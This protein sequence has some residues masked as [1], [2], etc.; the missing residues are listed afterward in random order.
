MTADKKSRA[1]R[2]QQ[3]LCASLLLLGMLAS[4]GPASADAG[5]FESGDTQLRLDLLLL[6]DARVIRLPVS[7]WPL[8]RA[9][10]Q[11]ALANAKDHF[12]TNAA[13][14]TA[15]ARL[16]ARMV[17]AGD[18][19]RFAASARAGEAGLLR[20]FDSI[21]REDAEIGGRA[22]YTGR[23]FAAALN[24]TAAVD[25]DDGQQLRVDGSHVTVALGN[26]LVSANTLER[27]W[28]PSHE[29]SLIL[30]N[31]A[32]P[33]PTLMVE[34]A[35]AIP[36]ETAWLSWLGPWRFNFAISQMENERRD[37]DAPLFMAWR[38]T[39]MPFKDIEFGV[40]RTAQFCGKQL[41]CNLSVFGNLLV[42]NDNVGID[43]T[44]ENEPGNQMAGFDIRWTSPLG[45]WPYAVYSQMIGEDE[46]SYFPAK[47]LAQYGAEMWKPTARGGLVQV[48]AEYSS[49]TCSAN[50]NRGPYYNCAY[51]QGRFNTEGYRYRGRVI[52]YTSD[53][54]AENYAIGATFTAPDGVLWSA[55]ARTAVLNRD[56]DSDPRNTVS[57]VRADYTALELGWKGRLFG[58]AVSVDL[59]VESLEPMNGER[60]FG[61]FGFIGWR[62]EFH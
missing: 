59:G 7:Q 3:V 62:H 34:R 42:G 55:T 50:T 35:A 41:E 57:S 13:V 15:L 12:A 39:I 29:S 31:N 45:D 44:A 54:D 48:F 6:N 46:S 49:T 60:D 18:E 24:F 19:L 32:R 17:P 30:S 53:R 14:S 61:P 16:R 47:Y 40:S 25:P 11:Y 8:P 26:W 1:N 22:D 36:F 52:G 20:D 21:S 2:A 38:V 4:A 33:M 51:N 58:E 27:F 56:G 37:I 10:V 43:A 9:A 5:W 28:G 23:R